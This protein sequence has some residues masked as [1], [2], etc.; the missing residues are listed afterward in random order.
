MNKKS[1]HV[2]PNSDKGGWDSK[3]GGASR[4]SKHFDKKQDAI[5]YSREQSKK[6]SGELLIHNKDGKIGQ[7]NSHGNDPFPPKG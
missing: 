5:D 4:A 2:L 7:K 6:N 3:V 1:F